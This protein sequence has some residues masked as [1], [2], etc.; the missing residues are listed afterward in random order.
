[1]PRP[2]GPQGIRPP[3]Q[4]IIGSTRQPE[5]GT[6]CP[7]KG[8]CVSGLNRRS[9]RFRSLGHLLNRSIVWSSPDPPAFWREGVTSGPSEF[10]AISLRRTPLGVREITSA[11]PWF[12]KRPSAL[13][14]SA[15]PRHWLSRSLCASQ[16][17]RRFGPLRDRCAPRYRQR[18]CAHRSEL[19]LADAPT[20]GI[21]L[22]VS[23]D[24]GSRSKGQFGKGL[25]EV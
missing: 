2:Q 12:L 20:E 18:G 9:S 1:M 25:T 17:D 23:R 21:L 24:C 11:G 16:P 14:I 8:S 19:P 5:N 22:S 6:S 3:H 13:P 15:V 10:S 7:G 4:S